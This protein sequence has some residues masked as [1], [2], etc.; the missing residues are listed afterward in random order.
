M[1]KY[2]M[3]DCKV[4]KERLKRFLRGEMVWKNGGGKVW[5]K[6]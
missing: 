3:R 5:R 4:W 6:V 2:L 1:I